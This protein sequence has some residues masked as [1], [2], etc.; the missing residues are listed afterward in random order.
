LDDVSEANHISSLREELSTV[1]P[2]RLEPIILLEH[3]LLN[4]NTQE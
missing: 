1:H 2:R 3:K 4:P